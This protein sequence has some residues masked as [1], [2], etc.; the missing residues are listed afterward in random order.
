M[1]FARCAALILALSFSLPA[2]AYKGSISFTPEERAAHAARIG[3][4]TETAANCLADHYSD[5]VQFFYA[6]HV[7]KYF[8]N[9]RY[10]KGEQPR[11][12]AD[13]HPLTPIRPELRKHGFDPELERQMTSI[14]CVDL[15]RLCLAEGFRAAGQE[16]LWQRID[17][18]NRLNGNIGPVIQVGLQA[19]GWKL[20]YWNPDPS[21]NAAWDAADK[22][23]TPTNP[24]NV[25]GYHAYRYATVMRQNKYYEYR[26]DDKTTLVGF[27]VKVPAAFR[28]I[29]FF[30][31]FAHTGYH[32]FV[33]MDGQVVEAHS[34]RSLFAVD[35]MEMSDFNPLAGEAPRAT[36]TEVY[37][38]G[39][40]AVP[41]G[42]L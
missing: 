17:A 41:P 34:T 24:N 9:R 32:V 1:P 22:A 4:V 13:G 30:M 2:L 3:V 35:N 6:H 38:S 26:V 33:G 14:S 42:S 31:G 11:L 28:R 21:Q 27:G 29:P 5:H 39:L 12:R 16:D 7:S 18:F 15:A 40:I 37:L 25:W 20:L 10:V 8:G 23:R 19:L 36:R